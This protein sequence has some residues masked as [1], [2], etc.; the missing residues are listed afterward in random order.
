MQMGHG[1]PATG[2]LMRAGIR[3]GLSIDTCVS[4]GGDMFGTMR[5]TLATQ[6]AL[7]NTEPGAGDRPA[8]SLTCRDVLSF[9]TIDGARACQL[10]HKLGSLTPGKQ[11]DIILVAADSLT[12][13]PLNNPIGQIV[14]AA[15][16]GLVDTVLV[17]G[18]TVKQGGQLRAGIDRRA[19]ELARASRDALFERARKTPELADACT[20][21]SWQPV[22][23]TAS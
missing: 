1:W 17:A 16:P 4:N 5:V 21:G 18:K 3:P 20:G 19:R 10:D 12:L 13:T 14:Y 22:P 6:R 7:D 23:L 9:A 11:A 2:R 8:V 15:H